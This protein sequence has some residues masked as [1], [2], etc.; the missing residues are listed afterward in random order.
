LTPLSTVEAVL[1]IFARHPQITTLDVTGGSPELHPHFRHVIETAAQCG[2]NVVLSSNATLLATPEFADCADFLA[3]HQVIICAS[4]PC[5]F[6]KNV[7]AQRGDGTFRKAIA[8]LTRLSAVGYGKADRRLELDLILNPIG[9]YLAPQKTSVEEEYRRVLA[10]SYKLTFNKLYVLN[11]MP[12]G[13]MK[14]ALGG[15]AL[16]KYI[17]A[18][19]RG[20]NADNLH[21]LM[22]RSSVTFGPDDTKIYDCDFNRIQN[23]PAEGG[24]W[25]LENFDYDCLSRRRI[26]TSPSCFG[27]TA[28]AGLECCAEKL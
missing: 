18:L 27:C 21:L 22:C 25:T 24:Q 1:E 19:Q 28:G 15:T 9:P 11:N 23:R 6:E 7:D 26:Q 12:L 2:K 5:V 4:L 3:T 20:F 8:S 17:T 10:E 13:R 14:A 16:R